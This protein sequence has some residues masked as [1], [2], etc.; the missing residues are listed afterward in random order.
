MRVLPC[1]VRPPEVEERAQL[2]SGYAARSGIK[3]RPVG[4]A[5]RVRRHRMRAAN[6]IRI[7]LHAEGRMSSDP[8]A[9]PPQTATADDW[10]RRYQEQNTPWD[11]N[12]SSQESAVIGRERRRGSRTVTTD[13]PPAGPASRSRSRQCPRGGRAS[14][15]RR[16][17][18]RDTFDRDAADRGNAGAHRLTM[19]R[20]LRRLR[21]DRQIEVGDPAAPGGD[22][23]DREGQEGVG[24]RATPARIGRRK[25]SPMS[26]SASAPRRASVM[27]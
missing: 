4:F 7:E 16:C 21:N 9:K 15:V 5:A 19:G 12:A 2:D 20:D 11:T 14:L 8:H 17:L 23:L 27:A 26:P 25:R 24:W 13:L 22:A 6:E 18:D 10:N 1:P 3:P